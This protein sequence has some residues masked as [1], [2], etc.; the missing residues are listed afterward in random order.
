MFEIDEQ[1]MP[2]IRTRQA[3]L[4]LDLQND[5][6]GE[7]SLL[8][9]ETPP[10]YIDNIRNLI[11]PFR[12]SGD[13]IWICSIS[14]E[15][16]SRIVNQPHN[17]SEAI[18][19]D[20][21]LLRRRRDK[22]IPESE[23][24]SNEESKPSVASSEGDAAEAFLTIQCE[25]KVRM[26]KP[27]SRGSAI[28]DAFAP[29][30][31]KDLVFNKTYYSAFKDGSLV[32]KLRGKFV[33][34]IYIAGA[35]T[36]V[37]VFATAMDA[38]RHGYA[39]TIIEDCLGYRSKARH[40]EALRQLRAYTGCDV[41]SSGDLIESLQKQ[42]KVAERRTTSSKK[43]RPKPREPQPKESRNT[44]I[45]N[46]MGNLKLEAE[47]PQ[48]ITVKAPS[49]TAAIEDDFEITSQL[50]RSQ[51]RRAKPPAELEA[52]AKK[53]EKVKSKV[54]SRRHTAKPVEVEDPSI[55]SKQRSLASSKIPSPDSS[56]SPNIV[57]GALS[58]S[59][60]P[61][62][63]KEELQLKPPSKKKSLDEM[64]KD[65]EN[66]LTDRAAFCEGDTTVIQNLLPDTLA[67]GIFEKIRD[68]VLWQKMGHQ[69]G[70]VPRLVAV[71]GQIEEDGSTPIYRHPADES[72]ALLSFSPTVETIKKIVEKRLG[73]SLNHVL[74][75][76]YRDGSDNIS[77]HSDKTLD[78]IPNTF[79]A[80]V[81]LGAQ[82]TM[83]FRTKKPL[84]NGSC[85]ESQ[86][87]P[88]ESCR[89]S[90]PHNS[91]CKM[92]LETNKKWLHGI[93]PDKR[94][95]SEKS[96]AELAYDCG[97]ISLTFRHIG[98]YLNKSRQK[99]WGQG[100]TAKRKE[101]AVQVINGDTPQTQEMLQAFGKE[102][103]DSNFDW[104]AIYGKGFDVLH[105]SNHKKLFLSGDSITDHRVKFMLN[106]YGI[107]W[108]E[109]TISPPFH[110]K[111]EELEVDDSFVPETPA[112]K[113]IDNDKD[114]T[115][116]EGCMPIM[117]YIEAIY[118]PS[119]NC[120]SPGHF[121][122]HYTRFEEANTLL[123]IWRTVPFSVKPFR[124]ELAKWNIYAKE[125]K[126]I[127]GDE[128]GLADFAIMP[129][130]EMVSK[131][132]GDRM[133]HENLAVY[134]KMMVHTESFWKVLLNENLEALQDQATICAVRQELNA[135]DNEALQED[136]SE[137]HSSLAAKEEEESKSKSKEIEELL[138]AISKL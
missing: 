117:F 28:S 78:I 49:S 52:E 67:S 86:S 42:K 19:T 17:D 130:F 74:I 68:E 20:N 109:A 29:I 12:P 54:K 126:Y 6:I 53:R 127:A 82:R 21:E 48:V 18:I 106:H 60:L 43:S 87:L 46:L 75:Q 119:Q 58:S 61:A 84:K 110:W 76:F 88:R 136:D 3:L 34:E 101:D 107:P 79:I 102:N 123:K 71:Q 13:I 121:A 113:F 138:D 70:E 92:G 99:I 124:A 22:V 85:A 8:P 16:V 10:S 14:T 69:G 35:L 9:V 77:E 30:S 39:I 55:P 128:I 89:A 111:R 93:R 5:F 7:E 33:T 45:E 51:I 116:V 104:Q 100:A 24:V 135:L 137:D 72:P 125:A 59:K 23:S 90:L 120:K 103:H 4:L 129:V 57:E 73:H 41:I 95:A 131:V 44:E 108:I 25:G 2:F 11:E 37:S 27:N 105:M 118:K 115:T 1:T 122:R 133:A 114:R 134:W 32:Q 40:D 81:S 36:N 64:P 80:N 66:A 15:G 96:K 63:E 26:L 83:V 91:L 38:A 56:N 132:W 94:M 31:T 47:D 97:R 98:T 112:I 62:I 50:L 65:E